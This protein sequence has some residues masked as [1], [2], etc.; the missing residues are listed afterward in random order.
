MTLYAE[1]SA[2]LR[3]LFGEPRGEEIE[4]LLRSAS[5]AVC[6]RLTLIE[7]RRVAADRKSQV[8]SGDRSERIRTYNFPQNRLTD[9]RVTGADGSTFTLYKLDKIITGDLEEVITGVTAHFQAE[10]LRAVDPE[11]GG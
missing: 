5:K 6:S 9:H 3:W 10:L 7:V 1:T 11:Q 4:R 8:G 2:E